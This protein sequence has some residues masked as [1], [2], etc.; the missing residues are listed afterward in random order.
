MS[1]LVINRNWHYSDI[2]VHNAEEQHH[3][4]KHYKLPKNTF[5][6]SARF[7]RI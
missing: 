5:V 3:L 2:R 1:D 6:M 4:A 7:V